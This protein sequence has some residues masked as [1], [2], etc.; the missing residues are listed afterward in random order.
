M[1]EAD[2]LVKLEALHI[3]VQA[4]IQLRRDQDAEKNRPLK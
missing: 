3:N 2:V 1:P 4:L